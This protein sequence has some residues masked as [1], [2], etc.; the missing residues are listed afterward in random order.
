MNK[1]SVV[2]H[3]PGHKNS[4][5]ESAP[6]VIE[7]HSGGKVIS[8]HK[9]KEEAVSHLRDI[10]GHKESTMK[11]TNVKNLDDLIKKADLLSQVGQGIKNFFVGSGDPVIEAVGNLAQAIGMDASNPMAVLDQAKAVVQQKQQ[12]MQQQVDQQQQQQQMA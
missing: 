1:V 2:K 6:W 9:T 7:D 4:K 12:Q 5:G 3:R 10:E 11:F 8:S